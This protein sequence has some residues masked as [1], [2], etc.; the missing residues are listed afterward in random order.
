[1]VLHRIKKYYKRN[2]RSSTKKTARRQIR[3]HTVSPVSS[4]NYVVSKRG[5]NWA[6]EIAA[7][8]LSVCAV[9]ALVALLVYVDDTP[10]DHWNFFISLNALISILAAI[11][12]ASLGFT[13]S[14]CLAQAK[15]NWFRKR[16]DSLI[17][18]DRFDDASRGPWGSLWLIIWLRTP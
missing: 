7:L 4:K 15:W 16:S 17:G 6:W 1:M 18:F 10:L 9:S 8:D 13:I 2:T 11:S 14:S 12:R 3:I 5:S